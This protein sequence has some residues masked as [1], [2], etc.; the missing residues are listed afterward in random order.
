MK[1]TI[2][3]I[4]NLSKIYKMDTYETIALNN[5]SF[6]V[7]E[8]EFVSIMGPSGSG[9]STLMQI[10]GL[11]DVATNGEYYL[12]GV[13]VR[14]L[15]D[16]QMAEIRNQKI[17][18]VFQFFN[19]LP[20]RDALQNVAI[21]MIYAGMNAKE[22]NERASELLKMVGL[23][24]RVHHLSNQLSGGQ[25]QRVA[26]ARALT[27]NPSIILADEPT[28]NIASHQA[29]EVM[30]IFHRMHEQGHTI[31]MITHEPTIAHHAERVITIKDGEIVSDKK[32]NRT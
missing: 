31:V 10:I 18:F 1:K 15:N 26:I 16:D 17:G 14:K 19:L 29:Q 3:E 25:Q 20:R 30:D 13:N 4:Q 27:L 5:V 2:I 11:L 9:K 6:T 21:P 28:G 23:E 22:R 32:S 24:Q 7:K 8:G 12:D